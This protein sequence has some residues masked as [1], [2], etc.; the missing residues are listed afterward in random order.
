M[1]PGSPDDCVRCTSILCSYEGNGVSNASLSHRIYLILSRALLSSL[2]LFRSYLPSN[3]S[4]LGPPRFRRALVGLLPFKEVRRLRDLVDFMHNTWVD[5]LQSKKRA[6]QEGD[7]AVMREI[8]R[9]N[10]VMS[11][12]S[13]HSPLVVLHSLTI[14]VSSQSQYRSLRG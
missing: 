14:F 6:L 11:I 5:L 1:F 4:K 9:G 13:A 8:G 12:L 10:D 3:L 2:L 7:E